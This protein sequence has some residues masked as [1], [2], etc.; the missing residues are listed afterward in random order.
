M[1]DPIF[2]ALIHNAALLLAMAVIFDVVASSKTSREHLPARLGVG[3]LLGVIGM[4]IMLT[5]WQFMQG[6][7][8][9]T[10]S[11]LLG[12][13]GL[14]FGAVPTVVAMAM[15]ATLR[16]FQGGAAAWT[17][18][19]VILASGCI[20]IAWRHWRSRPLESLSL[21]EFYLFGI[22]VHLVMLGLMFTLPLPV[23]LQVLER[24]GPPVL[25]I[26]P[27]ATLLLAA[28]MVNRLRRGRIATELRI[29]EERLRLATAAA[30]QGLYDLNVQTGE[31][32]VNP[33]YARM[34]GYDP[35]EFHETYA[36]WVERL[37]PEDREPVTTAYR[38]YLA[39][40][41]QEY[42]TQFRQRTRTGDWI[43]ILSAGSL[44]ERD[45]QGRPS[46]VVGTHTDI[47]PLKQAEER[48]EAARAEATRLLAASDRA[49]RALLSLLEDLRETQSRHQD[50]EEQLHKLSQ[51]V[52]QSPASIAIT[53]LDAV[54]EY[55]N[56]AFTQTTGYRREEII[57]QNPRILSAGKTPRA[58]YDALWRALTQGQPWKGELINRRK[59]GSEYTE[60]AIITPLRQPDGRVTH[61]VA[62]KEDIT[63]KKRIGEE[64]DR[65]RHHLEELVESRTR[66]LIEARARAEAASRAKSV[67]LA[68]MSHEIRTP[69]N[70]I[71]GLTHLLQRSGATPEQA[72][73]LTKI[74]VAARHL[75][76]LIN[77]ILDLSKIEVG[78]LVLEQTNFHLSAVLDHVRSL[79]AEQAKAKGL[80]VEVDGDDVPLWLRG[81]PTRLRQALLNYAGNAVKFTER[82]KISLRAKL[83]EEID[84]A[85]LVRFEVQDTGIGIAPNQRCGLFEAFEQADV[86]TTRKY[87][88][89][90]LGLA[91]TRRLAELMGG[92]VGF[93]SE[94]GQGSNFWFTV[95]LGRGQ[96]ILPAAPEVA[97]EDGEVELRRRHAGARL[98]LAEDNAVNREVALE[99]LFGAGLAVDTAENGREAVKKV[100]A[101]AYDLILMD[102]QMPEM[103][104]LEATRA[105]RALPDRANLPI[106]AMTANVFEEDRRACRA[107]G[108]NDFVAKPVD[109][110]QL[111]A[112]LLRWLPAR[113][114]QK[115][116]RRPDLSPPPEPDPDRDAPLLARL[117]AVPGLDARFGLKTL[118]GN[119]SGYA[120]LLRRYAVD[121]GDDLNQLRRALA[122]GDAREAR[123]LAHSLKGVSSNLGAT[124][125]Q[126][127][128]AE[129][130]VAIKEG[131][132]AARIESLTNAVELHLGVLSET[133][134]DALGEEEV[135]GVLGEL[136]W[137]AVRQVFAQLE[138]F[139]ATSDMRANRLFR[140]NKP[141]L[142]AAF[143]RSGAELGRRIEGY[144][145]PEALELLLQMNEAESKLANLSQPVD[146]YRP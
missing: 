64:L 49:R 130:E 112:A 14:F 144:E 25:A 3:G 23:A 92:G 36:A 41:R 73:R 74:E 99:L 51:V 7:F 53:N 141:L 109:P 8:F 134:L 1:V 133:I 79:I 125:I 135:D 2:L 127:L 106:L 117:A 91:I 88:G 62:I 48:A 37:H 97:E 143:G 68:N 30:N 102:V 17:G 16:L 12:I 15:T 72:E 56:D 123:R 33:E 57:G 87:G 90:G 21:G 43:W 20:G 84:G 139:L 85:L 13:S 93:E 66:Q 108:M 122:A 101:I 131:Q 142:E 42:R 54:I 63:E 45:A 22:V 26:Y 145:Y 4:A 27:V 34:L 50:S 81:D 5:P 58:T 86:S 146:P 18:V 95:W 77:D 52:E 126:R 24:I 35:A 38:N 76:S 94:P 65:H 138:P 44:V 115:F 128:A 61:Y 19:S 118:S 113:L 111:F 100:R 10:R 129:L 121:H 103:D 136:D 39:G 114:E 140:E 82:G 104:G 28:L 75:L 9:D 46:R 120:R 70:A 32:T 69:M 105:I 31:A 71:V 6:I 83:L 55:V 137:A 110:E 89:T 132:A 40:K 124:E 29:S 47:T 11:V 116:E 80:I 78:K 59:D 96:G 67:F 107:A 60:L 98:L 119:L